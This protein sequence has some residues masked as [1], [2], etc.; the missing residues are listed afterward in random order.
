MTYYQQP[1]FNT[2]PDK[3]K[4]RLKRVAVLI[5][6]LLI[7]GYSAFRLGSA[8]NTIEVNN[9]TTFWQKFV[10]ILS[11]NTAEPIDK[12]YVMPNKEENRFD[13]LLLG[14]RGEDGPD[15]KDAG[16]LLAD[17]IMVV[18][19]DKISKKAS[20]VSLPRDLYVKI[21]K[22]K[23]DKINTAYEYGVYGGGGLNFTKELISKITGVYIDKAVVIN[24]SSFEKIIDEIGGIDIAL[25]KPF[26]ESG[27]W[28]YEFKLPAGVNHLNGQN[29]L[30][31][32]RSRYSSSDFD[33]S[34]RQ[35]Q[36]IFAIKDKLANLN[37]WSNPVKTITAL[38]TLRGNIDTDLNIWNTG[39][40][41]NMAKEINDSAKITKHVIST[42]N[43]V[44]ESRENNAYILLPVGDNFDQIKNFFKNLN[45]E[46]TA[47]S[48][49]P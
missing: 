1:D 49:T 4:K 27:Q 37:F 23:N 19:Y 36:V 29:A 20:L 12:N 35:Q 11:F 26:E 16:P 33:R 14:I 6:I 47:P 38:N 28:G 42:E 24:F 43:L 7:A 34:R 45:Q 41:L 2:Y 5:L 30:Y 31:Y 21:K 48:P 13:I 40:L 3:N 22:N 9:E 17:T 15:A 44:Y 32:A 18:S 10:S 25:A 8:F 46:I 39:D